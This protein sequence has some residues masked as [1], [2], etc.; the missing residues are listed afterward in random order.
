[1]RIVVCLN[2]IRYA[3]DPDK[4]RLQIERKPEPLA[5]TNEEKYLIETGLKL[6]GAENKCGKKRAELEVLA[7][8]CEEDCIMLR[9]ALAMGA[10]HA[11]MILY[12]AGS[13]AESRSRIAAEMT[14]FLR[15]RES[16]LILTGER[17]MDGLHVFL[18]PQI[19]AILGVPILS[20]MDDLVS[21]ADFIFGRKSTD[22][23][24]YE[25][26][27]SM[28]CLV[29]LVNHKAEDKNLSVTAIREACDKE[30]PMIRPAVKQNNTYTDLPLVSIRKKNGK[31][32]C[33]MYDEIS[34]EE[35]AE[36]LI[37]ELY[38]Q[39][40]ALNCCKL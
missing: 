7:A 26:G 25:P 21:E 19:A 17:V 28:P 31:K 33:R 37:H 23:G 20:A 35:A 13:P 38:A 15:G 39:R 27:A 22:Y 30:I 24:Q 34:V 36:A 32:T 12:Q 6:V 29:T 18:G 40:A 10:D 2:R 11:Y 16:S 5:M 1:M 14:E 4:A 9:E 3:V 8:G